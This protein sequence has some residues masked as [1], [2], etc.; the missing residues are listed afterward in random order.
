MVASR[1][2]LATDNQG[3]P[4]E[5]RRNSAEVGPGGWPNR[6]QLPPPSPE[7]RALLLAE[8]P[9][10]RPGLAFARIAERSRGDAVEVGDPELVLFQPA[11]LV[12]QPRRFLELEVGGGLAHALLEVADVRLEVVP[13]EVRPLVVAGVDDHSVA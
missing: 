1:F 7:P 4:P 3:K 11:D 5:P 13:D 2:S 6:R 9:L 8:P 12:A 10:A